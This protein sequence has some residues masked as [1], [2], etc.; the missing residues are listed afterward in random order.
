MEIAEGFITLLRN[1][2]I[3]MIARIVNIILGS[4]VFCIGMERKSGLLIVKT[5]NR[6]DR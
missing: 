6:R 4:Y 5:M 1:G 3:K 2:F